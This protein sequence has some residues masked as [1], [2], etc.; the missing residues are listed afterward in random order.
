MRGRVC[1]SDRRRVVL[2]NQN[3]G[4]LASRHNPSNFMFCF[5]FNVTD[6]GEK[7]AKQSEGER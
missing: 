2:F 1:G 4:S 6:V 3:S 7:G 5:F